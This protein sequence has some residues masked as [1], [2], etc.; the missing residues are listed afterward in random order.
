MITIDNVKCTGCGV[1]VSECAFG[2]ITMV[3]SLPVIKDTCVYCGSCVQVCPAEAIAMPE[4][5]S[6]AQD[7]VGRH[8][9]DIWVVLE[10]EASRNQLRK[11]SLELLSEARRLADLL[12]QEVGGVLLCKEIPTRLEKSIAEVGCDY[13][14]I[15]QH[16]DLDCYHTE[17]FSGLVAKL[18]QQYKPSGILFSA[19]ENGRDMAPRVSCALQAGLTADC[20]A[21]DIDED[22]NLVQIRPTYGGNIMASIISPNH[23]PQLASVRPNVLEVKLQEHP[24]KTRLIFSDLIPDSGVSSSNLIEVLEKDTV[25]QDVAEADVVIVAGYGVGSKENFKR[26]ERLAIKMNAAIGATRKVV[27][28]GWAP[29]EVQVGQ[30]GKTISPSLYIACGVSGALQHTI[31]MK[32][33]K[34]KI[35]INKDPAAPIFSVCDVALL[36]DCINI[37]EALCEKIM[38]R[39]TTD[40]P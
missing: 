23:R 35:A 27:D 19:T 7:S 40:T 34:Y 30:T 11:V 8:H 12:G 37:A 22:K 2:A 9:R 1:C 3:D 24:Y 36:G 15:V 26:L 18:A 32:N 31:G 17:R 14:H 21:L 10:C 28:E 25:Y 38:E 6:K 13:L 4:T 20:T 33:A 16:A 39:E 29:F 5:A